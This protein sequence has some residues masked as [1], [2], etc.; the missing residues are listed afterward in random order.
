MK[1]S[2]RQISFARST[3]YSHFKETFTLSAAQYTWHF[4]VELAYA[5]VGGLCI[6]RSRT[7]SYSRILL[8]QEVLLMRT[9]LSAAKCAGACKTRL[10]LTPDAE[11]RVLMLTCHVRL[12]G[13]YV[14]FCKTSFPHF[15]A[16][17]R[18][19]QADGRKSRYH[20][21]GLDRADNT[22]YSS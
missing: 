1:Q 16:G 15:A 5:H 14:C 4:D 11:K 17:M 10:L 20:K 18:D 8:K 19:A 7:P 3:A 21:L 13:Y 2:P 22:S 9:G 12:K 6:F